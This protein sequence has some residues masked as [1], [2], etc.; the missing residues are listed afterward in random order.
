MSRY[1]ISILWM[2][3]GAGLLSVLMVSYAEAKIL[4]W[5]LGIPASLVFMAAGFVLMAG[6]QRRYVWLCHGCGVLSLLVFPVGTLVGLYYFW[7]YPPFKQAL[8]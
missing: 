1:I 4:H 3:F 7:C 6:L 2:L 5:A 8:K